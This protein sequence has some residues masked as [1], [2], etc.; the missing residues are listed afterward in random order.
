MPLIWVRTVTDYRDDDRN[1]ISCEET[2]LI[3][4]VQG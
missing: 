3:A 2:A 1:H 4:S